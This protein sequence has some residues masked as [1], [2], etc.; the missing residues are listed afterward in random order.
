MKGGFAI[1]KRNMFLF[2]CCLAIA[3]VAPILYHYAVDIHTL[4]W[5][6]LHREPV[7]WRGLEISIPDKLIAKINTDMNN[8]EVIPVYSI[9]K[10]D[11]VTIFFEHNSYHLNKDFNFEEKYQYAGERI[12]E[13]KVCNIA[14]NPCIWIK[15]RK[16]GDGSFYAERVFFLSRDVVITFMGDTESR[17]Y[18]E[19]ILRNL[20]ISQN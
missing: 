6:M 20:R 17:Y 2:I 19:E 7:S 4:A 14:N 8:T 11:K 5:H 9:S 3:I 1:K 12:I 10:P 13:K 15:S 16:D 18:L